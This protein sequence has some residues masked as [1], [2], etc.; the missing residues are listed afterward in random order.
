MTTETSLKENLRADL[1]AAIKG[2]DELRSATLRMA[3][4]A[5][6]RTRRSPGVSRA[7]LSDT[8]VLAV[9]AREMKKRREAAEAFA[10][11]GRSRAGRRERWPRARCSPPTSAGAADR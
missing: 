2:R 8:E 9:L 11:A 1:T 6:A 4:A 7:Q 10:G 3:L 5:I